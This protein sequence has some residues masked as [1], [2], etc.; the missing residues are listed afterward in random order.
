MSQDIVNNG[1]SLPAVEIPDGD[2]QPR[3]EIRE[4][5]Y[6]SLAGLP[7]GFIDAAD[8]YGLPWRRQRHEEWTDA[9]TRWAVIG[10]IVERIRVDPKAVTWRVVELAS[11]GGMA[12]DPRL[13]ITL[14]DAD[15]GELEVGLIVREEDRNPDGMVRVLASAVEALTFP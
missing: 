5:S 2:N 14:I 7:E 15:G 13:V 10:W 3:G 1:P 11:A 8:V 12:R 9:P 4:P 6:E